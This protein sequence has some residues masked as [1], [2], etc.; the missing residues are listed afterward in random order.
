MGAYQYSLGN[1]PW[2]VKG[3]LWCAAVVI[4]VCTIVFAAAYAHLREA[5]LRIYESNTGESLCLTTV[6]GCLSW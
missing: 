4:F 5:F 1:H 3:G 6:T 2:P